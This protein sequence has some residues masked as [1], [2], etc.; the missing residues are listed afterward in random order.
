VLHGWDGRPIAVDPDLLGHHS[1][2]YTY[3]LV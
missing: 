1:G 3:F 2:G